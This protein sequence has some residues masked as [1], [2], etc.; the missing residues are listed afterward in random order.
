M[1]HSITVSEEPSVVAMRKT[2]DDIVG[3]VAS[4]LA[5]SA[6]AT[7]LAERLY[8]EATAYLTNDAFSFRR[9]EAKFVSCVSAATR[10]SSL[11]D[12]EYVELAHVCCAAVN[13]CRTARK[14]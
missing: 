4:K 7:R 5:S 11:K 13:A 14:S 3:K 8:V 12:H 6:Q 10:G 1:E 2:I 9:M